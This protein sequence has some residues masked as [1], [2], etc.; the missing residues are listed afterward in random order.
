MSIQYGGLSV[1]VLKVTPVGTPGNLRALADIT[2]GPLVIHSCR[3][4]Q[5]PGQR[6]WVA[7]PQT[8]AADGRWYPVIRTDDDALRQNVRDRVLAACGPNVLRSAS[9]TA[10]AA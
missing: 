3:V 4:I 7:M 2:I 8:Q 6:P 9:E 1:T 10:V 5:Q